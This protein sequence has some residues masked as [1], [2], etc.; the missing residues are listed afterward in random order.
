MTTTIHSNGSKWAGQAP[1]PIELLEERLRTETL[2]PTFEDYGCFVSEREGMT[3]FWGNFLTVSAVFQIDTDEPELIDRL[4]GLIEA[5]RAMEQ[6]REA[7]HALR[8]GQ[9]EARDEREAEHAR[10]MRRIDE[11]S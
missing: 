8:R 4:S 6:Y 7:L 11:C 9:Q 5:N 10:R 3:R 2:D 1:D